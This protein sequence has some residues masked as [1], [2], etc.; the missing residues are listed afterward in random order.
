MGLHPAFYIGVVGLV[1]SGF[2]FSFTYGSKTFGRDSC[3]ILVV[4]SLLT[5]VYGAFAGR[6]QQ[7]TGS[8]KK[9]KDHYV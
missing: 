5:A 4:A 3:W 8:G 2:M 1:V 7:L 9:Y 6:K